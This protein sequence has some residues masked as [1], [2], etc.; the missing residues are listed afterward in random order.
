MAIVDIEKKR[1]FVSKKQ[2]SGIPA[3]DLF[4]IPD[5]VFPVSQF[6]GWTA[7]ICILI[8]SFKDSR[9]RSSLRG[10]KKAETDTGSGWIDKSAWRTR[11]NPL[12]W[13]IYGVF[14]WGRE[15]CVDGLIRWEEMCLSCQCS[16]LPR[17]IR[18]AQA[19]SWR[20]DLMWGKWLLSDLAYNFELGRTFTTWIRTSS[21]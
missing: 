3:S 1:Q 12:A 2:S 19:G 16:G 21:V 6:P 18:F 10:I 5:I 9:A 8:C 13:D 7:A 4:K 20:W 17:T 15:G 11:D 14:H